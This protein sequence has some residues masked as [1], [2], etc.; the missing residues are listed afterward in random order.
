M[1]VDKNIIINNNMKLEIIVGGNMGRAISFGAINKGVIKA[2]D[3]NISDP[4]EDVHKIVS[5]FNSE[6]SLFKNSSEAIKDVDVI[7]VSVKP[8]LLEEVLGALGEFIDTS[9]QMIVSI[10]AGASFDQIKSYIKQDTSSLAIYRVIPNTAVS[11][12]EGVSFVASCNSKS[13][14]DEA[15]FSLFEALGKAFKV[16]EEEMWAMTALSSC[17][18]AYAYKYIDAAIEGGVEMGIDVDKARDI[19]MQTMKGA[20]AM[21]STN[22]T[23][24]Q[25]EIDKVTTPGG[26]TLKGLAEMQ[27]LGFTEAVI[28]GLKASK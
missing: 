14:N 18:I 5:E 3:V 19:V 25:T 23:M 11:L 26:I 6:I 8:W 1:F 28:G 17:G 15:I 9:K 12:G 21:L 4:S 13:E 24:P 16:T 20:L 7:V 22:G 10:V 2:S 27:R